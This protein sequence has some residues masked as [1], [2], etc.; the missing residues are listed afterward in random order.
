[1]STPIQPKSTYTVRMERTVITLV[2]CEDCT[3]EEARS[4]PW[5]H[6]TGEQDIDQVDWEVLSVK[7]D[8]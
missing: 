3:E 8:V 6:A 4:N 1:M 2:T 7:E 5:D